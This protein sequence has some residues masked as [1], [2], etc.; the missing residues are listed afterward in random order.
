MEASRIELGSFR[1]GLG[2]FRSE[3]GSFDPWS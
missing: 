2:S 3:L 1:T